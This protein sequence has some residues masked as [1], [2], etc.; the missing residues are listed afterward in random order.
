LRPQ[1]PLGGR[2]IIQN[3]IFVG[4]VVGSLYALYGL[5]LT[6]VYKAT[7]VPNLAQGAVGTFGA[8][9]FYKFWGGSGV[10]TA[11]RNHRG[12]YF[13][14]PILGRSFGW[15]RWAYTPPKAPM[16]EALLVSLVAS[17]LLGLAL[18]RVMRRFAKA[19]TVSLMIV[20]LGLLTV[21]L[22]LEFNLFSGYATYVHHLVPVTR[23]STHSFAG[24]YFSNEQLLI[25]G[26]TAGLATALSLFFR[27][28]HLGI[29]I[30]AVADDHE[31][32]QLLGINAR[33]V[34][35]VSWV[36][37]SLL[38]AVAGILITPLVSLDL[39]ALTG[40]LLV[41]GFVAS[42]AGGFRSLGGTF[43]GGVLLGIVEQVV[44]YMTRHVRGLPPLQDAVA[45]LVIVGL[46]LARPRW[47]FSGI[48]VDEDSGVG[49]GVARY[50]LAPLEDVI[51][52]KLR[53]NGA[54]WI[55]LRDWRV[56]R[57]VISILGL[58]AI[59]LLPLGVSGYL[60][61]VLTGGL[62]Y[63]LVGL[64]I[65]ILTGWTGQVSLAQFAFVGIGAFA[66]CVLSGTAHLPFYLVV[67][68]AVLISV[69][70][71]LIIG[72]PSLRLRGFFLALVT[73][74]FAV[75]VDTDL[76]QLPYLQQH[77]TVNTIHN[78]VVT[79]RPFQHNSEVLYLGFAIT[80]ACFFL[81]YSLR[82]TRTARA[83]LA[84]RDSE[85][86]AVA[87]GINPVKY[88]LLAFCIAG[89][90]AA[91]GGS[92]FAYLYVNVDSQSF[93][94]FISLS[95]IGY[96]VVSGINQML[97]PVLVGLTF[98]VLPQLT[99]QT[100]GGATQTVSILGGLFLIDVIYRYP[101]GSAGF[102]KRLVRPDDET[103]ILLRVRQFQP[104]R[105]RGPK[106]AASNGNDPGHVPQTEMDEEAAWA[107]VGHLGD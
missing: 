67:P 33:T 91:A 82:K 30:R 88:K 79:Y 24:I 14:L 38:A 44:I 93:L 68:L 9:V 59:L 20:S 58:G 36:L 54:L 32:S 49:G 29:A 10:H 104:G 48:R 86:T 46:L 87:L 77:G 26:V 90:V 89:A 94:F 99:A 100:T 23:S 47:I 81:V 95:F 19:S 96:G 66:T 35:N 45:F 103:P 70:F 28:T 98:W 22:G 40:D 25:I 85:Q 73:L 75:A 13:N 80:A 97:G 65:V 51:R 84:I 57:W 102:L 60:S 2:T 18:S 37:G 7:R 76:F 69:P 61:G 52:S 43:A 15:A 50:G 5:G 42:L 83:W 8:F 74:A 106:T 6:V 3:Y 21:L 62:V 105:S 16:W 55:F 17:A 11:I 1:V 78:N 92:I 41:F 39:G 27:Y 101:N 64:S 34:S 56:G 53:G 63:C 31:V 71:S 107:S 72:I 4:I 12:F